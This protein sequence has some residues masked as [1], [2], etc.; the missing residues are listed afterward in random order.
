MIYTLYKNTH[1]FRVNLDK[2]CK[3]LLPTSAKLQ[4]IQ[5]MC[6]SKLSFYFP[7]LIISELILDQLET[8][9][10]N[11]VRFWFDLNNSSTRSFMFT[12]RSAG[13]LGLPHPRTVYYADHISF[14][15]SVLNCD[16][17]YMSETRSL[18]P[19]VYTC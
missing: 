13:G 18:N 15:L 14:Y 1:D 3:S 10:V 4:A 17:I 19:L 7:N 9:I 5:T 12:P 16:D 8:A 2:I 11:K 6:I